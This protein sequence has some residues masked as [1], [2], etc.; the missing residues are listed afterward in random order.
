MSRTSMKRIAGIFLIIFLFSN[1]EAIAGKNKFPA[2]QTAHFWEISSGMS[3]N[4]SQSENDFLDPLLK[5][6]S[7]LH[8][9]KKSYQLNSLNAL[10]KPLYAVRVSKAPFFGNVQNYPS[11][12]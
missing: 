6:E 11:L 8:P 1:S 10:K 2:N 12:T 3:E 9:R 5:P 7:N 4:F